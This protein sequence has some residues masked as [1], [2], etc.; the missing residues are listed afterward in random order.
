MLRIRRAVGR[1]VSANDQPVN[2]PACSERVESG[3][4][5]PKVNLATWP[6]PSL[7][8]GAMVTQKCN[9]TL[10]GEL[11][12]TF[13]VYRRLDAHGP[14][15]GA[16]S[17]RMTGGCG[18]PGHECLD[19]SVSSPWLLESASS[20]SPP[21]CSST[22]SSASLWR[23]G[24][25]RSCSRSRSPGL[26][27]GP[28]DWDRREREGLARRSGRHVPRWR[29][30]PGLWSGGPR[31]ADRADSRRTAHALR[32]LYVAYLAAAIAIST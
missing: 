12:S 9:L 21:T 25:L 11:S 22:G 31:R 8:F 1:Q 3:R 13:G 14:L 10:A 28:G 7:H 32:R 5:T 24:S 23:W 29:H 27:R 19:S 18:K 17:G 4:K 16:H 15:A 26:N 20:C 6:R 30:L 2:P